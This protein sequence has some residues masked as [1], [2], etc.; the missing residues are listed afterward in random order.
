MPK[1]K[2]DYARRLKAFELYASGMKKAAIAQELGVTRQ[3]IHGWASQDKWDTRLYD[4]TIKAEAAVDFT[5]ENTV[6]EILNEMRGK[7][8]KRLAELEA[9]CAPTMDPSIRL[10]AIEKWFKIAGM[11]RALPN[12]GQPSTPKG[13]E[14]IDDLREKAS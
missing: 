5:L 4:A 3:C 8:R 7:L 12:P 13:L 1:G 14:L 10:R 2:V 9:L 11:E 6:A